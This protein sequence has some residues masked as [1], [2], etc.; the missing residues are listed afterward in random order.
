MAVEIRTQ[1]RCSTFS[2]SSDQKI[3][4]SK[5]LRIPLMFDKFSRLSSGLSIDCRFIT[6]NGFFKLSLLS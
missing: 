4:T 1:R 6:L 5:I 3:W 2:D